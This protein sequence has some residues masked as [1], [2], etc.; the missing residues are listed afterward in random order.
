M[1][2]LHVRNFPDHLHQALQALA[3]QEQRSLGAEVTVL[4]E[5]ALEQEA[6]CKR[7]TAALESITRRRR[8]FKVPEGSADSL[9]LLRE[10]RSR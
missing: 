6:L 5:K 9:T 8:S 7:R 3:S 10:D 2:I 1:A 4:L